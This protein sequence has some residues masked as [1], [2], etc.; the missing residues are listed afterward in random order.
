MARDALKVNGLQKS[1]GKNNVL[2]GIDLTLSPGSV[3]VLMGA[4]GAGKSTLVKV[5]CGHHR[6]DGGTVMLTGAPFDPVDEADAIRKGVV[7]VHQSINDGVIPDLDVANNLMLDRLV[8]RGHGFFVRERHLRAEAAKVAAAMGIHVDL[9]ARVSDL[10]VADR[11]MIAIARAMARAPKVLILDEPTSSLSASEAERLFDLIDRLRAQGVAILY[12]SHRMSDIRRIADRIVVMRDGAISGLFESAPLDYNAAVTAMLGHR[13]TDVDVTVQTG[14]APVLD[15]SDLCLSDG[16]DPFNLTVRD[17]EVV[18][19]VGLL[20]SGKSRLAD[21]LF[22]IS[23]PAQ[24][25]MRI[26][27]TPYTPRSV[28][29]AVAQGVFMSPKDRSSNAVIP[30]FDIADNMTL[31]FLRSL[32][33][34]PF[35]KS[36]AQRKSTDRMVDQLGIVC[37]SSHDGIGTLSGGN[38]QKVMIA[39]WLLEPAKV[40][41]LDEPF[42]GVDIGARR[43]IGRHIRG[44][45]KGRATLV[46]LAE[47][48]EALEIADRILVMHE[49]TLVGEHVNKDVDLAA[50]IADVT[51]RTSK[52]TGI[53]A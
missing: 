13:M 16:T 34:G 49:G 19:L 42:Q 3:T 32:S 5:I 6:A 33:T 26:N 46:F 52:A 47:I 30:A 37:Q 31:P 29:D 22:G 4:N 43:D 51:G 39:R 14:A 45:A 41:L 35:L 50:L 2:R 18:A 28:E 7:T 44:T 15:L 10:S 21:I 48:D 23:Q 9:R 11:Q 17:G 36:R 53:S 25:Q 8:E 40:L 12:I 27:G 24:G 38:Q 20:G 1:F